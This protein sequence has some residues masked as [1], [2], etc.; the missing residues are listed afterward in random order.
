MPIKNHIKIRDNLFLVAKEIEVKTPVVE[1]ENPIHLIEIIDRSGSMSGILPTVIE[2]VKEF[3]R[4]LLPR[5]KVT[6]GWF[7][8]EGE[9]GFMLQSY[10]ILDNGDFKVLDSVL[11]RNKTTIGTTCFSEVLAKVADF[12]QEPTVKDDQFILYFFTDGE[13]VVRD[14]EKEL[15]NMGVALTR[16]SKVLT[17]SMFVGSGYYNRSMLVDMA[18]TAGGSFIHLEKIN[19]TLDTLHSC[20]EAGRDSEPKLAITVEEKNAFAFYSLS[21]KE[22]TTYAPRED[23]TIAYLPSK[24]NKNILFY[25]TETMPVGSTEYI[26]EADKVK[27]TSKEYK[28][29]Y[30]PRGIYAGANIL[31]KI[32]KSDLAMFTL[33]MVGDT[34]LIDAINSSITKEEFGIAE[35]VIREATFDVQLRGVNGFQKGYLPPDDTF[36]IMDLFEVLEIDE[37]AEF[38]P[39]HPDWEYNRISAKTELKESSKKDEPKFTANPVQKASFE[40]F[41]WNKTR[42][43][44][45]VGIKIEGTVKLRKGFKTVGLAENY[46]ASIFRTYSIITDGALNVDDLYVTVSPDTEKKLKK[47]LKKTSDPGVFQLILTGIPIS[48]RKRSMG[49]TSAKEYAKLVLAEKKLSDQKKTYKFLLDEIKEE[50]AQTAFSVEEKAK[51]FL[52]ENYIKNGAFSP[53]SKKAEP[54]DSYYASEFISKI[55]GM[56]TIS[57]NDV[58]TKHIRA[59]KKTTDRMIFLVEA[60]NKF[61]AEGGKTK[62]LQKAWLEN[63]LYVVNKELV[64]TRY[65]MSDIKLSILMARRFFEEFTSRDNASIEEDGI[66]ITF[67]TKNT[68]IPV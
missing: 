43:N 25:F 2:H 17:F 55:D 16:L 37:K 36:C 51:K 53:P 64:E 60:Y 34:Y 59:N 18:S 61:M 31:S 68:L 14:Y 48:N 56:S 22:I 27:K 57:A 47:Y 42:V 33:D 45:S 52:E 4:R 11:D 66:K 41:V 50:N 44:L 40:N 35:N 19:Q 24:K 49:K 23:K 26:V 32:T 5:D 15:R 21:G 20:S 65:K 10:E 6:I 39:N 1:K 63:E 54:T 38:Y 7:S 62:I 28:L 29:S 58:I 13:P 46:P 67:E 12:T 30:L 3:S 9:N 8:S